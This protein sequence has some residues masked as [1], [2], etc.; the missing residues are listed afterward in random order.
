MNNSDHFDHFTYPP[1]FQI[2]LLTLAVH[3]VQVA[4]VLAS[5]G[6]I[7]VLKEAGMV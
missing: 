3:G 5:Q 2:I 4:K 1:L 7:V 6:P